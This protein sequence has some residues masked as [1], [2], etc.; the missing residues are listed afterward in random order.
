M[1]LLTTVELHQVREWGMNDTHGF[2]SKLFNP[3]ALDC[4]NHSLNLQCTLW[5][6]LRAD[7]R[8]LCAL[9]LLL[10]GGGGG[11]GGGLE[12]CEIVIPPCT[13][14][15]AVLS[16][17]ELQQM[18]HEMESKFSRLSEELLTNLQM[19]DVMAGEMEAKNRYTTNEPQA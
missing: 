11:G 14:G 17:V 7:V 13:P 1:F 3:R 5:F 18:C 16:E 9:G 4:I 8:F 2:S 15:L 10:G 12:T 19:R 6:F